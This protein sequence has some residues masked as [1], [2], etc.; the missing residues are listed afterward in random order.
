KKKMFL[1][2]KLSW[3]VVLSSEKLETEGLKL[4]K[5]IITHLLSVFAA[6][7]ASKDHGYLLAVTTVDRIGEGRV[8]QH[9][10]EVLFPVEFSCVA[11]RMATGEIL[12]GTVHKI[13]KHGVFMRCGPVENVYLTHQKMKDYEYVPGENPYFMNAKSSRIERGG[14]VRF[15]VMGVK[16]V[17]NEKEFQAVAS[18]DGDYLGPL[19]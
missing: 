6:K 18:L 2:S 10:G 5:A 13:L 8:R 15:L 7:K 3:N 17:E 9:S 16:F 1:Q 14:V 19:S 12:E 11:F 4:Q